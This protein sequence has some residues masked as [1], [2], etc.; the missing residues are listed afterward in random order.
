MFPILLLL[1]G[2]GGYYLYTRGKTAAGASPSSSLASQQVHSLVSNLPPAGSEIQSGQGADPYPPPSPLQQAQPNV[3]SNQVTQQPTS[4]N[5]LSSG[6]GP[7]TFA[8]KPHYSI[9][10]ILSPTL[11]QPVT[12]TPS[13][14]VV[15]L[16]QG[17]QVKGPD[18]IYSWDDGADLT[19]DSNYHHIIINNSNAPVNVYGP[20]GTITLK[21]N[22]GW[23]V[24]ASDIVFYGN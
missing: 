8:P 9:S 14:S 16:N 22:T 2:G 10:S 18:G 23:D 1:L 12:F 24:D 19:V 21:P 7:V 4:G 17:N 11:I 5:P 13:Q 3:P 20:N 6:F 15:K